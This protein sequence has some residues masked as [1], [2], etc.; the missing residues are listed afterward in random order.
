METQNIIISIP[1]RSGPEIT[2]TAYSI[3]KHQEGYDKLD[4]GLSN[5]NNIN[6]INNNIQTKS[7]IKKNK[8]TKHITTIGTWNVRTLR[9]T[10]IVQ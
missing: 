4:A 1:D 3:G 6:S 10:G 5:N 8:F 9:S 7:L 2:T